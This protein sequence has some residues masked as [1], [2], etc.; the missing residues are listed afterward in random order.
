MPESFRVSIPVLTF[1]FRHED[2]TAARKR[3][4][5]QLMEMARYARAGLPGELLGWDDVD[6]VRFN[7]LYE[8]LHDINQSEDVFK[9]LS[10]NV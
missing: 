8:A 4:T 7:E 2:P 9:S 3:R 6:V 10:E 1:A 5:K